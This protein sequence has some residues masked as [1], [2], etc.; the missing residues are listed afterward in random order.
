[1]SNV[2]ESR[3]ASSLTIS[4]ASSDDLEQREVIAILDGEEIARLME[5]ESA[6]R[7]IAPG[8]HKLLVDNTWSR[9][10][11]EFDAAVGQ[12]ERFLV[13][14]RSG[15]LSQFLKFTFGGGPTS[16]EIERLP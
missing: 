16:I 14:N 13:T 10:T 2:Q 9:K 11:V 15:S 5:G 3:T 6:T 7:E 8:P 4:R 12:H 1:M